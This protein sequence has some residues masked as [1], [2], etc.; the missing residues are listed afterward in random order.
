[1]RKS[2]DRSKQKVY[3]TTLYL[4]K[5]TKRKLD[6]LIALSL[7]QDDKRTLTEFVIK[8]INRIHFNTF[9]NLERPSIKE[10]KND[11]KKDGQSSV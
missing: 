1:M 9:R 7:L 6:E 3:R 11:A 2:D 5:T 10:L 4:D 8:G